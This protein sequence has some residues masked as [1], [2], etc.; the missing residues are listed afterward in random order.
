MIIMSMNRSHNRVL[1]HLLMTPKQL[2]EMRKWKRLKF[3]MMKTRKVVLVQR[4]VD[5][6]RLEIIQKG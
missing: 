2:E 6:S 4:E 1:Y 5:F 3:L